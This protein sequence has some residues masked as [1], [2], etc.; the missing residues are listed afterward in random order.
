MYKHASW[1]TN[2]IATRTQIGPASCFLLGCGGSRQ[3]CNHCCFYEQTSYL[4]CGNLPYCV[5]DL[6]RICRKQTKHG[7]KSQLEFARKATERATRQFDNIFANHNALVGQHPHTWFSHLGY[8]SLVEDAENSSASALR[9]ES[10][11]GIPS[12]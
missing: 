4:H 3:C 12:K 2:I 9:N 10:T 11:M 5:L 6:Y 8:R 1:W 7:P